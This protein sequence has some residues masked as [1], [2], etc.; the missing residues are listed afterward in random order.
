MTTETKTDT[1]L[2]SRRKTVRNLILGQKAQLELAL[3]RHVTADRMLRTFFTELQKSPKLWDATPVSMLGALIQAAQ[4][5]LEFGGILGHAYLVPF[6]NRRRGN[7]LEAQLI[8]GYRG[9]LKLARNSGEVQNV[10]A[11]VVYAGDLF[12]YE[13]GLEPFL[14]HKPSPS[15]KIVHH[16]RDQEV[17]RPATHY[18]AGARLRGGGAQFEVLTYEDMLEHRDRYAK[19]KS[20]AGAWATHFDA[21]GLKTMVR[22]LT[23]LLPSSPELERA[24]V[25]DGQ[26]SRTEPQDLGSL[27]PE[28]STLGD[29][30]TR[31]AEGQG[32]QPLAPPRDDGTDD[33][34]RELRSQIVAAEAG[35]SGRDLELVRRQH[36]HTSDLGAVREPA[37]LHDY[38]AALP[39]VPRGSAG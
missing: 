8:P 16:G 29:E 1:A 31:D 12:E 21:M 35:L 15:P 18:Y 10:S 37:I 5:G 23:K 7:S 38:L 4:L 19:D 20:E 27:V 13:Y 17:L 26:A 6:N 36:L 28:A 32:G 2:D 22:I 11:H 14:R 25:L 24:L 34:L 9:L 3:P 39:K 30:F 33:E